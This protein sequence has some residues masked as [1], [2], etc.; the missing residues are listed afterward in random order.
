MLSYVDN[1]HADTQYESELKALIMGLH[2]MWKHVAEQFTIMQSIS[3]AKQSA[4]LDAKQQS[5]AIDKQINQ[6]QRDIDH[7]VHDVISK[8]TPQLTELRFVLSASKIAGQLERM[9]DHCKNTIK[10]MLRVQ[11]HI[12]P[13]MW[14]TMMGIVT[15]IAPIIRGLEKVMM[16]YTPEESE[17][18]CVGDDALDSSYKLL[19]VDVSEALKAGVLPNDRVV[20]VL[21]I[22]KNLERLADHAAAIA[23]EYQ[24]IHSGSRE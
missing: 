24:Y 5:K 22:A 21:F 23:Q 17:A 9:G 16:D 15:H 20:D 13:R 8:R 19:V 3:D 12:S 7:L 4:S 18:L 2:S 10:R 1:R 6:L 14:D 11:P